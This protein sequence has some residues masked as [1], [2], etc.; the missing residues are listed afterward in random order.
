MT[1]VAASRAEQPL[2]SAVELAH[3]GITVTDLEASAR[4][5]S[6][7]LGLEAGPRIDL[8]EAFSAGVTGVAEA[9]ISVVFMQGPGLAVE[10]LQYHGPDDRRSV[11]AR[12]CDAGAA[13]L[14][15][16]VDDLRRVVSGAADHGWTP[17]GAVQP[18]TI[19]PRA[20]GLAVY[21]R[22][23][24]GAVLELVQRPTRVRGS[25]MRRT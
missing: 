9:R 12:P 6:E 18:I 10:L 24:N 21:L 17:M 19:G 20:G 3:H 16:Y 15:L 25:T 13:H 11:D 4:F 22:E 14:A 7:V 5:F 1:D 2:I 8:D 23:P